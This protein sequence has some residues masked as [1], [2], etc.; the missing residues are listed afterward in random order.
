MK[1]IA[2]VESLSMQNQCSVQRILLKL[3]LYQ[4]NEKPAQISKG[5][6]WKG[7]LKRV[8]TMGKQGNETV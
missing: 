2:M 5:N 7:S 3:K 6:S 4:Q 1:T 8:V